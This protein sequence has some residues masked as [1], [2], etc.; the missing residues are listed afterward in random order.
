MI[1]PD[2]NFPTR[3]EPSTTAGGATLFWFMLPLI[4]IT[5]LGYLLFE[6]QGRLQRAEAETA[7]LAARGDHPA[8]GA[9]ADAISGSEDARCAAF[10]GHSRNIGYGHFHPNRKRKYAAVGCR[11]QA[12][13]RSEPCLCQPE[14]DELAKENQ[15]LKQQ[16]A[17]NALAVAPNIN[18]ANATGEIAGAGGSTNTQNSAFAVSAVV[19]AA[20]PNSR[21]DE[22]L[23]MGVQPAQGSLFGPLTPV[24]TTVLSQKPRLRWN[25]LPGV[26][27]YRIRVE[28]AG[29]KL[30]LIVLERVAGTEWRLPTALTRGSTF[31]WTILA[32][33]EQGATVTSQPAYFAVASSADARLMADSTLDYARRM[34]ALNRKDVADDLLSEIAEG[35]TDLPQAQEALR[36]R[37]SPHR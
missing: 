26:T 20:T 21:A 9:A 24:R 11:K 22:T 35:A 6:G 28:E 16:I 27:N 2:D 33:G 17:Q 7:R 1:R 32:D 8:T 14:K 29:Q 19:V 13:H 31:R 34:N 15:T 23:R 37:N 30:R 12:A 10:A 36:L 3:Y 25:P 18:P 4:V 5:G